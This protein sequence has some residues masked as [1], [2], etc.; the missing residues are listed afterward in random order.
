MQRIVL[1]G[2]RQLPHKSS[3]FTPGP[4]GCSLICAGGT[5]SFQRT[6]ASVLC[7]SPWIDTSSRFCTNACLSGS[8]G[9]L[10][11]RFF[12]SRYPPFID[13]ASLSIAS[14][15]MLVVTVSLKLWSQ[16][17]RGQRILVRTDNQNT[18]LAINTGRSRVF[19][20]NLAYVNFGSTLL[21]LTS[22]YAPFTSPDTRT[23]SLIP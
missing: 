3:L 14:L 8:G 12:H 17:L 13:A 22:N 21:F 15:E 16:E 11:G 9:S 18:E 1:H 10:D 20:F 6:R 19:L 5:I 4:A 2:L 7:S 23:P